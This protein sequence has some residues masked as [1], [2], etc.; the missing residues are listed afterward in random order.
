MEVKEVTID[1]EVFEIRG[2]T[3]ATLRHLAVTWRRMAETTDSISGR[4]RM[5][6]RAEQI[7]A[8]LQQIE[9]PALFESRPPDPDSGL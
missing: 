2:D 7:E 9:Q 8:A 6:D 5:N 1:G 3:L 4:A